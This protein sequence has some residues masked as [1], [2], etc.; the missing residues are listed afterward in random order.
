MQEYDTKADIWSLGCV[1]AEL[2]LLVNPKSRN[3]EKR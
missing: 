2:L 3:D 1:L